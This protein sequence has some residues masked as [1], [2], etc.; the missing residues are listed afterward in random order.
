MKLSRTISYAIQASVQLGQA[1]PD[2]VVPCRE[3]ADQGD[4]P[5]RFL[6]Q[7]LRSLVTHGILRSTRGVEGG[8]TLDRD[9][10]EISLLD[11]IEAIDGEVSLQLPD[12]K[13]HE[14]LQVKLREL[15]QQ[16]RDDLGAMKLA[17]LVQSSSAAATAKAEAADEESAP[18]EEGG[19]DA[20][21]SP[22]EAYHTRPHNGSPFASHNRPR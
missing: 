14:P 3:L 10:E 7:V 22:P 18:E 19:L 9:P 12:A 15:S 21:A 6:L 16:I 1:G 8:Y 13:N 5:E 11:I 2:A 17:A 20:P 4:M